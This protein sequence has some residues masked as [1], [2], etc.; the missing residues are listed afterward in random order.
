MIRL[1]TRFLAVT[2]IMDDPYFGFTNTIFLNIEVN[3]VITVPS[4]SRLAASWCQGLSIP[5]PLS[6]TGPIVTNV[7]FLKRANK[8][9]RQFKK[10]RKTDLAF[11]ISVKVVGEIDT[12][13]VQMF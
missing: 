7:F 6:R 11:L 5:M 3:I 13:M 2:S 10:L 4:C 1:L 9:A 12:K 8:K